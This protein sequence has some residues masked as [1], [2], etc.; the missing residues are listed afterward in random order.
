MLGRFEL[1]FWRKT[2]IWTGGRQA[3]WVFL[4]EAIPPPCPDPR[5]S[6]LPQASAA[7]S[8]Q[9]RR[10][11]QPET[12]KLWAII[13]DCKHSYSGRMIVKPQNHILMEILQSGLKLVS[14][15]HAEPGAKLLK[16]VMSTMI[17]NHN[18]K[19]KNLIGYY[20]LQ[21]IKTNQAHKLDFWDP[22]MDW[23]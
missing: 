8:S 7:W 20:A 6:P 14:D 22:S 23:F 4:W 5:V 2:A 19:T 17:C 21:D 15:E 11:F 13:S 10:L 16:P 18:H 3:C 9:T 1:R 12:T